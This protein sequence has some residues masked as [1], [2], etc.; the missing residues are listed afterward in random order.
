MTLTPA[1]V[2][3]IAGKPCQTPAGAFER[4]VPFG[5]ALAL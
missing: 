1:L 3:T 5:Q 4:S 2:P